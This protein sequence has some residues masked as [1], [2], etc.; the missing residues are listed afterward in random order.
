MAGR[1]EA[2]LAKVAWFM[3]DIPLS[4]SMEHGAMIIYHLSFII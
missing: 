4:G 3:G 1:Q 2:M